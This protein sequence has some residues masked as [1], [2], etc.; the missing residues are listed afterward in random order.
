[1]K[2]YYAVLIVCHSFPFGQGQDVQS[3]CIGSWSLSFQLLY[4]IKRLPRNK[5]KKKKKK[6]KKNNDKLTSIGLYEM[7][8]SS[9]ILKVHTRNQSLVL[10]NDICLDCFKFFSIWNFN[11]W[12]YTHLKSVRNLS[13]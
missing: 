10:K 6:K 2:L 5:K 11:I 3:D 8:F 7:L 1:M 9:F 12:L 13:T 4:E